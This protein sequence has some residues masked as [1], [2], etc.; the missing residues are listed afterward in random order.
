MRGSEFM[1]LERVES[2]ARVGK[3]DVTPP[4]WTAWQTR[5]IAKGEGVVD[6]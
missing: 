4:N 6:E 5:K 3:S 2:D 1:F